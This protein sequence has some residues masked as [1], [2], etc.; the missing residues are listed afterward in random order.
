[1]IAVNVVTERT[2]LKKSLSTISC[3]NEQ[4]L[5]RHFHCLLGPIHLEIVLVVG[6]KMI[7]HE[8]LDTLGPLVFERTI[9][10]EDARSGCGGFIDKATS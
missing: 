7:G 9:G 6:G 8:E 4:H 2:S 1:M 10:H 5:E 3:H